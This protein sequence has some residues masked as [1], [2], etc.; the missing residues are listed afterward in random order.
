[1]RAETRTLKVSKK[2]FSNSFKKNYVVA[3]MGLR[4]DV[5]FSISSVASRETM[6]MSYVAIF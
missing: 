5:F 2:T 4:C 3:P 1:M 6:T